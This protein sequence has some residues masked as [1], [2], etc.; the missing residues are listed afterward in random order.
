MKWQMV[1]TAL[2]ASLIGVWSPIQAQAQMKAFPT[3]E[4]Y[5]QFAK[6]GRGGTVYEVTTLADSGAGSLRECMEATGPRTCVF[7]VSG[8]IVLNTSIEVE[9]PYL[10]V[11]GQ[12]SPGGINI[13]AGPNLLTTLVY[14]YAPHVVVRHMRFRSGRGG[15]G[16]VGGAN[17]L[18]GINVFPPAH[19]VIFDHIS[20][21]WGV[22]E[23][24]DIYAPNVTVQWSFWYETLKNHSKGAVL[25]GRGQTYHHNLAA[26]NVY[27]NPDATG[28]N[29][30]F[31]NN[32]FYNGGSRNGEFYNR[33]DRLAL[34]FVSNLGM[35]GAN[36]SAKNVNFDFFGYE[37][38]TLNPILFYMKDNLD[39]Y[40]PNN[41]LPQDAGVDPA[42]KKWMSAV[43]LNGGI[44]MPSSSYSV[45]A[46]QGALDVLAYGGATKPFRDSADTR[47]VSEVRNCTGKAITEVTEV[48]G[49]PILPNPAP[50]AD[51][52]HD[53]MPDAWET[54]QALNPNNAADRNL[55]KDGDGYTNLE[56]Y[57]N[58]RAGDQTAAGAVINVIG[59]GTGS[60]PANLACGKAIEATTPTAPVISLTLSTGATSGTQHVTVPQGTPVT[61]TWN[62]SGADVCKIV[63]AYNNGS[64]VIA[65][66]LSGTMSWPS[67]YPTGFR[68]SC[69]RG[70]RFSMESAAIS[71]TTQPYYVDGQKN[72]PKITLASSPSQI[73]AG[74]SSTI[75]WS[76]VLGTACIPVHQVSASGVF[77]W[78]LVISPSASVSV[79]PAVSQAYHVSCVSRQGQSATSTAVTVSGSGTPAPTLSLSAS[80]ASIT[81]GQSST[82]TWSSTNATSC[83]ASNAWTG[84]KAV[85]GSQSVSP[86]ADATYSM[87]CTGAGGSVS[88]QVTVT[89]TSG[90]TAPTLT[91]TSSAS[92][93][94]A[95]Q[96]ATLTWSST[97]AT[98]CTASNAW[99]GAKAVSGSQSVSPTAT[100]TYALSCTGAGGSVS[101]QVTITVTPATGGAIAIGDTVKTL[102]QVVVYTQSPEGSAQSSQ[103][104]GA[105]GS[106]INGPLTRTQGV[107]WKVNFFGGADGW[108]LE[109]QLQKQ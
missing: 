17:S 14:I 16:V 48:G 101:R 65:T 82:L 89:V 102:S 94:T 100:A 10:T 91:L 81:A 7:R 73:S 20:V 2:V 80:P 106:V 60:L 4:G 52:D 85:S 6:G 41:S 37:S 71:L 11:A 19:D 93:I 90:P 79:T 24:I 87:T 1:G 50:P 43:P 26:H 15:N 18:D 31:V 74:Q 103:P 13:K 30:D 99:T 36:S 25:W 29:I 59:Q 27:R 9:N 109:S 49:W 57:L 8:D 45:D 32:I 55:D 76:T 83:T 86:T 69:T 54:A 72:A 95:G 108:V 44:S 62:S 23:A 67:D 3:A 96:S 61:L 51:A 105:T 56:E 42:D 66:S 58:E 107:Y 35:M 104:A 88:R 34:N 21:S 46:R 64:S 84:A 78:S 47:I 92:S 53:G 40:R 39:W 33:R 5:G 63:A 77:P 68:L 97:N 22:D 98:S 28:G 38:T 12:T 75:S 70:V